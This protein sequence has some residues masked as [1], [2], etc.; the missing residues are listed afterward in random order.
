MVPP[1]GLGECMVP[2]AGLGECMVPPVG[3]GD[4]KRWD[5][6]GLSQVSLAIFMAR[7]LTWLGLTFGLAW[8][9]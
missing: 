3:L 1:A 4:W 6:L 5:R 8:L 2:L 9:A 7:F